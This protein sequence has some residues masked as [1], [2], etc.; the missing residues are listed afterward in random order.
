VT[1]L[2]AKTLYQEVVLQHGNAPHNEGPLPEATHEAT[3]KNPLCGDR[4]TVR[5]VVEGET[6]RAVRFEARGCMIAR[7]SASLLTDAVANGRVEDARALA[8]TVESLVSG[9]APPADA[10][11]LEPLR[12]ARDF[13]ARRGCVTLAWRALE[14]A[15]GDSPAPAKP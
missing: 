11:P 5:L 2:D 7:A 15:L 6:V 3:K 14:A 9:E 13:P 1:D 8:V 12:G 4:V 10:G